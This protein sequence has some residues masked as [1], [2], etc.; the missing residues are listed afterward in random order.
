[1]MRMM[2]CVVVVMVRHASV[3]MPG[4]VALGQC[5]VGPVIARSEAAPRLASGN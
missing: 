2:V 5:D 3:I 4:N 1:M